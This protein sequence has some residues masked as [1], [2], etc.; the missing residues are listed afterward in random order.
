MI[1]A[2]VWFAQKAKRAARVKAHVKQKIEELNQAIEGKGISTWTVSPDQGKVFIDGNQ[3][4][5]VS[6]NPS[7]KENADSSVAIA[8]CSFDGRARF[9]TCVKLLGDSSVVATS[10]QDDCPKV[11]FTSREEIGLGGKVSVG[12]DHGSKQADVFQV[13][14][15]YTGIEDSLMITPSFRSMRDT[16]KGLASS[17]KQNLPP[18]LDKYI[19]LDT[20]ADHTFTLNLHTDTSLC[21]K[22]TLQAFANDAV[23]L[24]LADATV[25]SRMLSSTI[26]TQTKELNE[27]LNRGTEKCVDQQKK[28]SIV[29]GT[30]DNTLTQSI[31][32][33]EENHTVE[34]ATEITIKAISTPD[35]DKDG[36]TLKLQDIGTAEDAASLNSQQ[37]TTSQSSQ[38]PT[39]SPSAE[40]VPA[41]DQFL[42]YTELDVIPF[43]QFQLTEDF[44]SEVTNSMPS[45][46]Q[47]RGR[48]KSF[49]ALVQR[50]SPRLSSFNLDCID[51]S[52]AHSA[53]SCQRSSQQ[54]NLFQMVRKE[55]RTKKALLLSSLFQY[56]IDEAKRDSSV[57]EFKLPEEIAR[58]VSHSTKDAEKEKQ[59]DDETVVAKF[60]EQSDSDPLD[61][62]TIPETE[63]DPD[64]V[65]QKF[66]HAEYEVKCAYSQ[67]DEQHRLEDTLSEPAAVKLE[68]VESKDRTDSK[69]AAQP[70]SK[71]PALSVDL[72]QV[73]SSSKPYSNLCDGETDGLKKVKES[74]AL[75][76]SQSS[77]SSSSQSQTR[78]TKPKTHGKGAAKK[79]SLSLKGR[80]SQERGITCDAVSASDNC[81]G[82]RRSKDACGTDTPVAGLHDLQTEE[83]DGESPVDSTKMLDSTIQG[84]PPTPKMPQQTVSADIFSSP[85]L[86]GTQSQ[87]R[88]GTLI[89]NT[90]WSE[91][92]SGDHQHTGVVDFKS[93][94]GEDN[95]RPVFT[96]SKSREKDRCSW[97]HYA[98]C[99]EV[100]ILFLHS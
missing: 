30:V 37:P 50:R 9:V 56:L 16:D 59:L 70:A 45:S 12:D 87:S 55:K 41:H 67:M 33:A 8:D 47:S 21:S 40:S 6:V 68:L 75:L 78:P 38:Q 44:L 57:V 14:G 65:S 91:V 27:T 1:D 18:V 60:V 3:Q 5:A 29:N 89:K 4:S 72:S 53:L 63:I 80:H 23:T 77:T 24:H 99:A 64:F 94:W 46:S 84:L 7:G 61:I 90:A 79:M 31:T 32:P 88:S 26:S 49:S 71:E 25:S 52:A 13:P 20:D 76:S 74:T 19:G 2:V 100:S 34:P 39:E 54:T 73:S 86:F 85:V 35:C 28:H 58:L 15:V 92:S 98:G 95:V 83:G 51:K 11:C 17:Y 10:C 82:T 93:K 69:T 97:I 43:S 42:D 81:R 22:E 66:S 36:A 96:P 62:E 48:R